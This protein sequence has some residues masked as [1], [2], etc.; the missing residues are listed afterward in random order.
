M[1]LTA[2]LA[3][4]WDASRAGWAIGLSMTS[5]MLAR[6]AFARLASAGDRRRLAACGFLSVAGGLGLLTCSAHSVAML[7]GC[8]LFG[9]GNCT[10]NLM[11]ALIAHGEYSEHEAPRVVGA[12]IATGQ[13]FVAAGPLAVGLLHDATGGYGVPFTLAACAQTIAALALLHGRPPPAS[14]KSGPA[15]SAAAQHLSAILARAGHA[16]HDD[17][18]P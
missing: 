7:A 1:H 8:I 3:Q 15:P 9:I 4:R 16:Q 5:V 10:L 2:Y 6:L 12:L 14:P 18:H 11:P 13:L 17:K